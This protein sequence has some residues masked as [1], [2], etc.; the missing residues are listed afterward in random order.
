MKNF[1]AVNLYN[2]LI[3][4]EGSQL[5]WDFAST[6]KLRKITEQLT[7][8]YADIHRLELEKSAEVPL[9]TEFSEELLTQIDDYLLKDAENE[10]QFNERGEPLILKD[11]LEEVKKA[12]ESL[13]QDERYKEAVQLKDQQEQEWLD[14][15]NADIDFEL[16]LLPRD[17][18]DSDLKLSN[19]NWDMLEMILERE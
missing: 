18:V 17:A 6:R 5:K 11:K 1:E 2:F 7:S 19:G 3:T 10:I 13:A 9:L 8:L 12:R 4:E 14:V 15:L 16:T